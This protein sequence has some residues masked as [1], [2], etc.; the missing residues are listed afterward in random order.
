MSAA[1][2]RCGIDVVIRGTLCRDCIDVLEMTA[3]EKRAYVDGLIRSLNA[4]GIPDTEIAP[5]VGMYVRS[6]QRRRKQLGIPGIERPARDF[7]KDPAQAHETNVE[8]I[9]VSNA[10]RRAA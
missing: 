4:A 3:T 9:R 1:C 2:D 10:K 7:W 8:S 5:A 6:V